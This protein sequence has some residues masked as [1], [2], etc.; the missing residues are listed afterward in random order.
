MVRENLN[1]KDFSVTL[2][3]ELFEL[4]E[5]RRREKFKSRSEYLRELIR[6]DLEI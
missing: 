1:T 2:P 6:K 3:K 4:M 5:K